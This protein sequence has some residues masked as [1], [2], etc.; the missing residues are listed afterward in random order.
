MGT[1]LS[2]L[3]LVLPLPRDDVLRPILGREYRNK[4]YPDVVVTPI[5]YARNLC[6]VCEGEKVYQPRAFHRLFELV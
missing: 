2:S 3:S 1:K 4:Q 6:V 5:A